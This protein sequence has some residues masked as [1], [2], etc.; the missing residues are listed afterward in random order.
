MHELVSNILRGSISSVMYALLLLTLT[1]SKVGRKGTIVIVCAVFLMNMLTSLWFY[2]YGDLTSLSRFSVLLF[3]IV[4]FALKPVTKLSFMQ[5]SFTFLTSINIAMMIIVLSFQLGK[6]FSNPPLANIIL[7]LVF[8]LIVIFLFRHYFLSSYRTVV[9]NWPS[10]SGL[11]VAIFLNFAFYFYVTDDIQNTLITYKW[12]LLLLVTLSVAAYGTIFYSLN[13]I[14]AIHTLELENV[15]FQKE[16]GRLHETA[17]Q[18][19]KYANYD[20]LTGLPNRRYFFEKLALMIA[21]HK[22]NSRKFALLYIDLDGFKSINDTFGHEVG[23]EVLITVGNR[24][25]KGVRKTDFVARLGGDEFGV[26]LYDIE[27]LAVAETLAKKI[28]ELL[29]NE[30]SMQTIQYTISASIGIAIYPDTNNG[31]ETLVKDADAAMYAVK[32]SGKGGVGIFAPE[33]L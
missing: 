7:R 19:E 4:G 30:I 8:Y 15:R 27:N 2:V 25:E 5:W 16:T 18:L 10:F 6:L 22:H 17:V 13:K 26:I 24:L 31:V 33:Q 12:P 32:K 23:D 1:K 21:E 3:I 28:H 29:Q 14:A 20:T 11:M 9:K